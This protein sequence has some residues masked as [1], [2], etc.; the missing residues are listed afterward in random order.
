MSTWMEH[1]MVRLSCHMNYEKGS[2]A[3]F[4]HMSAAFTLN[5]DLLHHHPF[6]PHLSH[7]DRPWDV[8]FPLCFWEMLWNLSLQ[9]WIYCVI[10]QV[11]WFKTQKPLQ[12]DCKDTRQ[13][14]SLH[15]SWQCLKG[16]CVFFPPLPKCSKTRIN[17]F[18][19]SGSPTAKYL[20][21]THCDSS[22]FAQGGC[23]RTTLI[24]LPMV[25][26]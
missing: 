14:A 2:A 15:I 20:Q 26:E 5:P 6:P 1:M 4:P 3:H 16:K 24:K 17:I 7:E 10:Q 25:S 22:K 23:S 12:G 8:F 21:A 18:F 19:P 9:H 13:S 11:L